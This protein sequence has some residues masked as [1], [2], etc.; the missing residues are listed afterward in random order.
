MNNEIKILGI[1]GSLRRGS[2]N[3]AALHAA[4][5]LAPDRV[6]MEVIIPHDIPLYN[7]DQ[8]SSLPEEVVRLKRKIRESDAI[9]FATPEYN[10]S[11]TGVIK[12]AIDWASRPYG[13]SAWENKAA[14]V[15][16]ASISGFGTARAQYQLRQVLVALN[17]FALNR[18]EV[19]ISNAADK[20]D[21]RG[22]LT[23][24][25]TRDNLKE[26]M[27]A[28]ADWTERLAQVKLLT[29]SQGFYA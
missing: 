3:R 25:S 28:L 9:I 4:A 24:E 16:G 18:P 20:F 2:C 21:A 23:D 15:M 5:E 17:M 13:E 12:N 14:A 1:G 29:H 7:Q 10:Y 22:H 26:F 27:A 19:L 8:D 11:F 6:V